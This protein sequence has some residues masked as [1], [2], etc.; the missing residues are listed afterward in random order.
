M[1]FLAPVLLAASFAGCTG[2]DTG[3]EELDDTEWIAPNSFEVNA[4]FKSELSHEAT[5]RYADLATDEELQ[6]ELIGTQITYAK[7]RMKKAKFQVNLLPDDIISA[8]VTVEGDTVKI[9]YEASVDMVRADLYGVDEPSLSDLPET[10]FEATIPADPVDVYAR[11]GKNC[12]S[13]YGSYT[14]TEYKYYYYF[15]ADTGSCEVPMTT[16]TMEVVEVYPNPKVYPEYDR[17]L[18]DLG[19]GTKGFEAAILPNLGDHDRKSR[20]DGHKRELD[21]LTGMEPEVMGDFHRYRWTK[22]GATIV[23]DLY[24]PTQTYFTGTFHDALGKYQMVYYNGHSNYGNQPF[25]SNVDAYSDDYQILGMHS[26]QS[27]AYYAH[28]MAAG[29][30]T[31]EDPTGFVNSDMIATG[32]S[33]YPNDSPDV[34]AALLKGLMSGLTAVVAGTS[35]AAPSWQD[36]GDRMMVVAPSI[37]YGVAGARNNAWQPVAI[38]EPNEC[39]HDMCETGATLNPSC[40]PCAKSI[41]ENDGYCGETAWDSYC[42]EA[43]A[44]VCSQTCGG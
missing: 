31:A 34:M 22:D 24:D 32:R 7:N 37:L 6:A 30:A 5:G 15:D 23:I 27:Y 29:K 35:E 13:D 42:V 19:D 36:I 2:P 44:S 26:C 28:Q 33:S 41:I 4:R 43:V 1:T 38:D 18:N 17:L 14:L 16:G 10:R 3:S 40:D 11:A 39:S 20:F 12:A 8:D 25:L 21:S 9:A